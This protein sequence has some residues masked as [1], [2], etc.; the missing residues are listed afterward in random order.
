M[1]EGHALEWVREVLEGWSVECRAEEM[2]RRLGSMYT[3]ILDSLQPR[4]P[5]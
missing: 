1:M 5:P 3:G 4:D 2:E